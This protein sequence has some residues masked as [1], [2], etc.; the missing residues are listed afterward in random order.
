MHCRITCHDSAGRF[1][2]WKYALHF[3]HSQEG[4]IPT[5]C[6]KEALVTWPLNASGLFATNKVSPVFSDLKIG[7]LNK[8]FL[9]PPLLQ[10]TEPD[11]VFQVLF[12]LEC[13]YFCVCFVLFVCLF[14]EL[15]TLLVS[16]CIT[17]L[18]C[19]LMGLLDMQTLWAHETI[20]VPQTVN[21][22]KKYVKTALSP[23]KRKGLWLK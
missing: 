23:N 3:W 9:D 6:L 11:T 16:L 15:A 22:G 17:L 10:T 19:L 1:F 2:I 12:L 14:I 8:K 5:D 7:P 13:F 4:E 18:P 21:W 20:H